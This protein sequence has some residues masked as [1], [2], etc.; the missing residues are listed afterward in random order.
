MKTLNSKLQ[1]LE[2]L[3]TPTVP[4]WFNS[5]ERIAALEFKAGK[6]IGTP[7]FANSS[8][9]GPGGGVSCQKLVAAIYRE[10]GCCNVE[11]PEVAMS[12]ARFNRNSLMEEFMSGLSE[13]SKLDLAGMRP[14]PPLS[15]EERVSAGALTLEAGD[16]IGFRIGKAIHHM[17]IVLPSQMFIH[18][19]S[20]YGTVL[21]ALSDGTWGARVGAVWRPLLEVRRPKVEG[22]SEEEE[23]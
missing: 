14:L 17:G 11:V 1:T 4:T 9:P 6:W 21:S 23:S 18:A 20:G 5:P 19:M 2:K 12:H 22:R 16:L 7:F 10:C 13:F 8:M 3:Q 15:T